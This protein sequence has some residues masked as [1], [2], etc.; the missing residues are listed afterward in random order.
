MGLRHKLHIGR[1]TM[2]EPENTEEWL[3]RFFEI[4]LSNSSDSKDRGGK[5]N[6]G[7]EKERSSNA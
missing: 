7:K 3:E 2:R 5:G 6:I 1:V 4:I